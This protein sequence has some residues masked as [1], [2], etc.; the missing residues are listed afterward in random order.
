MN[1]QKIDFVVLESKYTNDLFSIYHIKRINL[2][3]YTDNGVINS[4]AVYINDEEWEGFSGLDREK[5]S[6][7]FEEVLQRDILREIGSRL[8]AGCENI[9]M[10]MLIKECVKNIKAKEQE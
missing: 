5:L 4:I 6:E 9:D 7:R 1:K 8:N 10:E 3:V 2:E